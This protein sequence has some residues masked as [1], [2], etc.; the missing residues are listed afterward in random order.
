VETSNALQTVDGIA[1]ILRARDLQNGEV[2]ANGPRAIPNK[3]VY[4]S[5]FW[6]VCDN[7]VEQIIAGLAQDLRSPEVRRQ[8]FLDS[9]GRSSEFLDHL[10]FHC[11]RIFRVD[12]R[13]TQ[14]LSRRQRGSPLLECPP[15]THL[16]FNPNIVLSPALHPLK[17]RAH[18]RACCSWCQS[19][20]ESS[21]PVRVGDYSIGDCIG[22][23]ALAV[24][25]E[26]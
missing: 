11:G 6:C 3:V 4:S 20:R 8:L 7:V 13:L 23:L 14:I 22:A 26:L 16:L 19:L 17:F 21:R 15:Y 9:S 1:E 12:S 25:F 5:K 18:I 10:C 24:D 2:V